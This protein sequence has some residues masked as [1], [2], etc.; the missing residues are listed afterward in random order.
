MSLSTLNY[1]SWQASLPGRNQDVLLD[2]VESRESTTPFERAQKGS[3]WVIADGFGPRDDALHASRL[4]ARIVVEHYWNSAISDP[5]ARL[6]TAIERANLMLRDTREDGSPTSG[7]TIIAVAVVEGVA[8]IVHLG[9]SRAYVVTSGEIAQATEDHTWVAREVAAGNLAPEEADDHPRRN[10]LTRALG[11]ERQV[12]V[13]LSRHEII[14]DTYLILASDGAARH[15]EPGDLSAAIAQSDRDDPANE[16]ALLAQERSGS[17]SASVVVIHV[18]GATIE[19]ETTGERLA[20]L[21][22]AGRSLGASL[23]LDVTI[24]SVM[25]ELLALLGGEHAAVVLCS[26]QGKPNFDEARQFVLTRSGRIEPAV[27]EIIFSRSIIED[28]IER[29]EPFI[30]G[31]ALSDPD[32]NTAE[33]IVNLS[34]R[35]ILSVPLLARQR[36]IGA[37]YL[38]SSIQRGAFTRDDLNLMESFAGQAAAAIENARLHAE[39]ARQ[40]AHQQSIIRSMSSALIAIDADRV[41]TTWNPAAEQLTGIRSADAVGESLDDVVSGNFAA[42]LRTLSV[43]AEADDQTMMI[44]HDWSGE[45]GERERVFLTARVALLRAGS[46]PTSQGFVFLVNDLT[47]VVRLEEARRAEA[48]RRQQIRRLFGRYLAPRVVEHLLM[49]P[50]DV[51]LGGARQEVTILF[52]DLRGYT[53]LSEHQEPEEVVTILNQ[54]LTLATREI[55]TELGTLDKFLGDGMMAIF[56]APVELPQHERAAIRAGLRMQQ[57]IRQMAEESNGILTTGYGVGIN[58]GTAIVGNI[59]TPELMNYT[60][61]GDA[62]NVAARLQAD[63]QVGDVLISDAT[64]ERVRDDFKVEELGPR[65]VKG[66]SQPVLVYRVV[67]TR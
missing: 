17:D 58:T 6:R 65:Q 2:T 62:V 45:I 47:E 64:Y 50:D 54:Y 43:Q 66:R 31:D 57:R 23:D 42:W 27:G 46:T 22:S 11:I 39:T 9:R 55:L 49:N 8:H 40:Q 60:A 61:I 67:G 16:L 35:S 21:Q 37:L 33:S 19:D 53:T 24:S 26:E 32:L 36:K 15:I 30:T 10:V 4:A 56:N 44:G 25:Q 59:G 20:I 29:G 5:P 12:K 28:V 3:I 18:S 13:D 48:R 41:V 34:L 51:Q 1:Q 52:A 38:D 7:A 63:A 14:G